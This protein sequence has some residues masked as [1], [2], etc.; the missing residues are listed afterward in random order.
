MYA[1]FFPL[2]SC[3]AQLFSGGISYILFDLIVR[4]ATVFIMLFF[5]FAVFFFVFFCSWSVNMAGS[6]VLWMLETNWWHWGATGCRLQMGSH[7]HKGYYCM[8]IKAIN[9]FNEWNNI[10]SLYSSEE[11]SAVVYSSCKLQCGSPLDSA[12][13]VF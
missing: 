4:I 2:I 12:L 10:F 9:K 13:K 11:R 7:W 6:S 1:I 5:G 8:K 3:R